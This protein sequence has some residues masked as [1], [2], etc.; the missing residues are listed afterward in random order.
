[1]DECLRGLDNCHQEALCG[2]TMG[3]FSCSCNDGWTGS[4]TLCENENECDLLGQPCG[5]SDST[6]TDTVGSFTC[7]CNEGFLGD[8]FNCVG[9]FD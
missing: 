5:L 6:C 9:K 2:N 3:S 4:G 8:G 7:T 1:M